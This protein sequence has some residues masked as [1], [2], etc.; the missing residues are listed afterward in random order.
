MYDA[1]G[2]DIVKR[3]FDTTTTKK[4]ICALNTGKSTLKCLRA[5]KNARDSQK[6]TKKA[7][8]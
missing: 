7:F 2:D 3:T 6:Q 4:R 5:Q 8:V 1:A